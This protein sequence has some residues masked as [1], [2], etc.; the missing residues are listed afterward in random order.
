MIL[1][2]QLLGT[3]AFNKFEDHSLVEYR[4]GVQAG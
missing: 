1:V 4:A 3:S 2:W